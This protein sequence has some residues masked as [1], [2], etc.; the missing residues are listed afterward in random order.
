MTIETRSAVGAA[1]LALIAR[2]AVHAGA[3]SA[4][5]FFDETTTGA[6]VSWT[7][8][9]PVNPA[10]A[11]YVSSYELTVVE[12]DVTWFGI[13]FN[14]ID[15]T[16]Q[17]PPE[18]RMGEGSIPGPAPILIFDASVEYPGDPDPVCLG[19]HLQ[20]S[21]DAAGFG[22]LAG[23]DIV[24]GECDIDIGFGTVTVQLQSVRFAGQISIDALTCPWD[25]DGDGTVGITDFLELLSQWGTS[26]VGPPDFDGDGVV[27]ITD[28]LDLLSAWGPCP[29]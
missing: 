16:D 21:L 13:P 12:V 22:L 2:G 28:F 26:P 20:I 18:I 29:E 1:V 15:V 25:L 24:L 3:D 10:A 23:T 9:T 11:L 17:I 6:D 19:A 5:W 7:S 4:T 8:P 27:G 14:D